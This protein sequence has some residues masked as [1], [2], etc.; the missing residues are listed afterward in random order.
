MMSMLYYNFTYF[1]ILHAKYGCYLVLTSFIF[2][3]CYVV[4]TLRLRSRF[5]MSPQV[6]QKTIG[7]SWNWTAL[8]ARFHARLQ[9]VI[10]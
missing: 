4:K 9:R 5:C 7:V 2:G 3:E 10:F 8:Q 1:E 6:Y